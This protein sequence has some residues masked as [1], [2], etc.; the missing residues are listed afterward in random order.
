MSFYHAISD[1][2]RVTV[3]PTYSEAHSDPRRAYYA[4]IYRIRIE[5]VGTEPGQLLWRHWYIHDPSAGDHEVEGE[6]VVGL[7]PTLAPGEV[8]QYE[9]HCVL[10]APSGHM[11][12]HYEFVRPDGTPFRVDIPRFQL[13]I[14]D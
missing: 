8:H 7:Q 3:R 14:F 5:N 12:G 6:G 13:T 11:E 9:S 1:G 4:F 2:I 10:R